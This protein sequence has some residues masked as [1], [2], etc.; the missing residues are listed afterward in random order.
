MFEDFP[1]PLIKIAD[2][3]KPFLADEAF[4]FSISHCGEYVA[5]IV[6][7]T[8]RVGVDIEVISEK[9]VRIKDKFLKR[10][11]QQMLS[12]L[13]GSLNIQYSITNIQLLNTC[14]GH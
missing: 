2:T 6:S 10:E 7:K 8:N 12:G 1:L 14:L 9:V 4:H 3:R 11:E 5:A 13:T